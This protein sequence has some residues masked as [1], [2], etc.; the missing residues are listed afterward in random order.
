MASDIEKILSS[1]GVEIDS[2]KLKVVLECLKNKSIDDLIA[3][4]MLVFNTKIFSS[5]I[6]KNTNQ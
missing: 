4:G 6:N 1:V 2:E 5:F 3:E